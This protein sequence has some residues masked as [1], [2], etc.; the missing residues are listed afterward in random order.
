MLPQ[1]LTM[2]FKNVRLRKA[3]VHQDAEATAIF[4]P[5]EAE[6]PQIMEGELNCLPKH[7]ERPIWQRIPL[8]RN[9]TVSLQRLGSPVP[10]RRRCRRTRKQ[11]KAHCAGCRPRRSQ[12]THG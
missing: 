12:E 9:Q 8:C 7:S 4:P 2:R 11:L 1:V 10:V 3:M 5:Y 6:T